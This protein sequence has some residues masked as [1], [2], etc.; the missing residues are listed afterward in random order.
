MSKASRCP[1]TE[2][3]TSQF[4]SDLAAYVLAGSQMICRN[5]SV[6]SL[7]I[8]SS[9]R[10]P[11]VLSLLL[12]LDRCFLRG[13]RGRQFSSRTRSPEFSTPKS[14]ERRYYDRRRRSRCRDRQIDQCDP[15]DERVLLRFIICVSQCRVSAVCSLVFNVKIISPLRYLARARIAGANPIAVDGT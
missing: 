6:E 1:D 9:R 11:I 8:L 15:R 14:G 4:H 7:T 10:G 5:S 12:A 2:L 3:I 13:G